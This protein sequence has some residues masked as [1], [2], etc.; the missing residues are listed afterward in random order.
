MMLSVLSIGFRAWGQYMGQCTA[1]ILGLWC[2]P[3]TCSLEAGWIVY[4]QD[5]LDCL[6]AGWTRVS[7]AGTRTPH[8]FLQGEL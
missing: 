4:K 1:N 2:M 3:C 6:E 7:D 8:W 5:C